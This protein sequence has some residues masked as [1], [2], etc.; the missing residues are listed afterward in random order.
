MKPSNRSTTCSRR[1]CHWAEEQQKA[2]FDMLS[3]PLTMIS[4]M[5]S[6]PLTLY[7]TFTNKSFGVL[8]AQYVEGLSI[9]SI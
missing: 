2:L 6:L 8:L 7:L 5:K 4:S 3:L 9:P 1:M